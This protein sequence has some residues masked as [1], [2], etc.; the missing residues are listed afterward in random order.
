MCK[1]M[2]VKKYIVEYEWKNVMLFFFNVSYVLV[3]VLY[4][5]KYCVLGFEYFDGIVSF[6]GFEFIFLFKF[7]IRCRLI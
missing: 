7:F 1:M 2:S 4:G 5:E 6:I 3:W